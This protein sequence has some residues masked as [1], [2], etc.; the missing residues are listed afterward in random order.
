VPTA[1]LQNIG[2]A[3]QLPVQSF[4]GFE[5]ASLDLT[6]T[7]HIS[8][9]NYLNLELQLTVDQFTGNSTDPTLPP[10]KATRE[11]TTRITVPNHQTVVIGGL[12]STRYLESVSKIPILGDIPL[13]GLLFKRRDIRETRTHLFI[14]LTPH[15]LEDQDFR[16][17][18]MLSRAEL[19][20]VRAEGI[21]P[22]KIDASYRRAFRDQEWVGAA[23]GLPAGRASYRSANE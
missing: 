2:A 16:D 15:I 1:Q 11:L 13:L 10:P 7:P 14:F 3:G 5:E 18:G 17:L 21:D 6:V 9:G 22:G 8:E 19:E 23:R 12:S 4:Q 20:A